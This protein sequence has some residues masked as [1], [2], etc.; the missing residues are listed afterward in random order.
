M[1]VITGHDV[2]RRSNN[3]TFNYFVVFGIRG[4]GYE[5]C[6]S[7]RRPT[8]ECL[9]RKR[10]SVA[11]AVLVDEIVNKIFALCLGHRIPIQTPICA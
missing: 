2:G 6:S 8:T 9:Y 11:F 7:N 4:D 10:L 5:G 3:S 1:T